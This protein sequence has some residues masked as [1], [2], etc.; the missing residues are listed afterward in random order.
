MVADSQSGERHGGVVVDLHIHSFRIARQSDD[1]LDDESQEKTQGGQ[2]DQ[3]PYNPG[4]ITENK[5]CAKEITYIK[6][7][8]KYYPGS[9]RKKYPGSNRANIILD[10][11]EKNIQAQTE[12]IL[13]WIKQRQYY[14]GWN[15]DIFPGSSRETLIHVQTEENLILDQTEKSIIPQQRK[16]PV[17]CTENGTTTKYSVTQIT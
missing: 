1:V 13:S 9:N 15:R 2:Q 12:K 10:Q 14:S 7:L 4:T 17:L 16:N 5:S 3:D 8:R 6:K 11:T